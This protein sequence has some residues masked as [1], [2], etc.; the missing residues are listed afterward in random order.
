M[1][2]CEPHTKN[3]RGVDVGLEVFDRTNLPPVKK[4]TTGKA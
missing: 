1:T 3:R 2:A 4:H